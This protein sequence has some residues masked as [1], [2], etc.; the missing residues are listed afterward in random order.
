MVSPTILVITMDKELLS[1]FY[2]AAVKLDMKILPLADASSH[3]FL[4]QPWHAVIVDATMPDVDSIS[5]LS[6]TRS[7]SPFSLRGLVVSSPDPQLLLRAVNEAQVHHV[8]VKPVS[9]KEIVSALHQKEEVT[10]GRT[11]P[12]LLS[13][14]LESKAGSG[15]G[16]SYRVAQF[17]LAIG[18]Q[19]GLSESE[20]TS[21]QLGCFFHDI[22]KLLLPEK[23]LQTT[24]SQTSTEQTLLQQHPLLG[25][26][27]VKGMDLPSEAISVIRHHHER[28]DGQGY[29][30]RLQRETIPLLARIASVANAYDHL[31]EV[32]EGESTLPHSEINQLLQSEAGRAFDPNVVR[33]V[34]NLREPEDVWKVLERITELPALA[35]IVQRVLVLLEREDFDWHEVAEIIAQDQNLAAQLLRL[36]N[37]AMTGLRR[38]VT[39]LTTA[40]RILGARPVRNLLLTLTVRPF[41]QTPSEVRLWE[42]SLA[43]ALVAR[44]LAQQTQLVDPEE[45]FT[46]GLLHDLGKTLLL[47]YFPQS[48]KRASSIA[49]HQGCP[50]FLMER[51]VFSVT[52]AEVGAWLLE[53]WRIPTPFCEAVAVHHIPVPETQPLAWHLYWANR[54]LHFAFDDTPFARWGVMGILPPTL[55]SFM[56]NPE[57]LVQEAIAQVKSVEDLLR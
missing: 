53:R 5:L 29:P 27:L 33:A 30:D 21:L 20:L 32:K 23:L 22:G 56:A 36:A 18:Q 17:A 25:E 42:H 52:H 45:A 50:T 41:L 9:A 43:C 47:R 13:A 40:L 15:Y 6:L 54:L 19:L 49:H 8:W 48:Y 11:F 12:L 34:L 3:D 46:A 38:R 35:P 16:H 4:S 44:R 7:L 2:T 31:T 10:G 37:S 14:A 57:Q 26:Q 39:S 24:D 1:A 51:L 55:H 28:W